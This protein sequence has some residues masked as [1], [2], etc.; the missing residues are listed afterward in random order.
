MK[1]RNRFLT[2]N[3]EWLRAQFDRGTT[4]VPEIQDVRGR[5]STAVPPTAQTPAP[6]WLIF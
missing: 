6:N 1:K 4:E 3:C 5:K 2:I